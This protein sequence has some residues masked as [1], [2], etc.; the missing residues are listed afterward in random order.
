MKNIVIAG[1]VGKDAEARRTPEG[2]PVLNFSVAV[3]D[4]YGQNKSTM[5][6]DVSVWGKRGESLANVV[7]KG[8]NVTVIGEFKTREHAGKT[9]LSVDATD[10]ELQGGARTDG[11]HP[12]RETAPARGGGDLDDEIPFACEWRL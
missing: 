7:R 9:Y 10:I 3:D 12:V 2:K 6:F 1:R 11:G 8:M 4:G 5:W